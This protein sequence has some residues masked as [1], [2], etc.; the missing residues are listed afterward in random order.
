MGGMGILT[1]H[2]R[3]AMARARYGLLEEAYHGEI[4]GLPGLLATG[5]ALGEWEENLQ[6][7]WEDWILLHVARGEAPPPL[8][9]VGIVLPH[10]EAA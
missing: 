1:C 4:P 6:A 2:I 5:K 7:P 9:E 8:G 3:E 10:G